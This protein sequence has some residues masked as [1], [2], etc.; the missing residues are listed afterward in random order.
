M[1]EA[2]QLALNAINWRFYAAIAGEWSDTR[3]HPWPGFE[4]IVAAVR[5]EPPWR[6]LDLG[7]GDGRFGQFLHDALGPNP[8]RDHCATPS[9]DYLGVDASSELLS[10][11]C[12]RELGPNYR[13]MQAD[14]V[15]S[16]PSAAG[17]SG[18]FDLIAVLGVLHHVP[19]SARRRALLHE[20]A[21]QLAPGGVLAL[22]FW[23]YRD[24]PRFASR[25]VSFE[26]YNRMTETPIALDQL[27]PGDTLLRWGSGSAPPR[28][29]HFPDADEVLQLLAA[30]GLQLATR[31]RADG[32]GE[33][34][35]EYAL[36]TSATRTR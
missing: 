27:E 16:P 30:T 31:F 13:F 1:D 25:V 10:H 2:T 5:C 33:Q 22:T 26:D 11:A 32:R 4:R 12:A 15:T 21:Q 29:C 36:L 35:N 17:A 3:E 6:V 34:L 9:I 8:D 18:P 28:Y 14:F 24:D 23:Q 7:C 20:L 19:A